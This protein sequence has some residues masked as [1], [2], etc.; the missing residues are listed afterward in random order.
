MSL[1]YLNRQELRNHIDTT[2]VAL[3]LKD[4]MLVPQYSEIKSRSHPNTSTQISKN[5]RKSIPIISSNMKCTT[6][7]NML[8]TMN[9]IG[10][11]AFL[12]R[13]LTPEELDFQLSEFLKKQLH[14]FS[15]EKQIYNV[16][17]KCIVSIGTNF[18]DQFLNVI[19]RWFEL[20]LIEGILIDIAHG[21][22][23]M[24]FETIKKLRNVFGKEI[25]IIAGNVA[26]S[27]GYIDL[28]NQGVDAV[29]VGIGGSPV[30]DTK[31]VTGSGVPLLTSILDCSMY[32]NSYKVPIIAD[33]GIKTSGDIAK[34]LAAGAHSVCLGTSLG[35]TSDSPSQ[36]ISF[37]DSPKKTKLVYGMSSQVINSTRERSDKFTPANEGRTLELPYL[38]DTKEYVINLQNGLK[39]ALTY[40]G[41]FS[42][43]QFQ[44]KALFTL[45]SNNSAIESRYV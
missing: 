39:S 35:S 38:G 43:E 1:T 2:K 22:S 19:I 3:S 13:F 10:A 21:H 45:I 37:L 36:E 34:C 24:V 16:S 15:T 32:Y 26:T 41:V 40:T 31:I 7:H 42:I 17:Y 29:R 23:K 25:D 20:G 30:C 28:C 6:E 18:S 12:H 44:E 14:S 27:S 33:G 4:I 9:H 5:I 8:K 11:S